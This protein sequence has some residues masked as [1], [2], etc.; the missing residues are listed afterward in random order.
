MIEQKPLL[1]KY[2]GNVPCLYRVLQHLSMWY[3]SCW[4][5]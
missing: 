4:A 2:F 1:L 3:K 5:Q